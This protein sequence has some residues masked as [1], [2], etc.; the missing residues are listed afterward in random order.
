V[1]LCLKP[2]TRATCDI[3]YKTDKPVAKNA[4]K[5]KNKK[6]RGKQKQNRGQGGAAEPTKSMDLW[7]CMLY[8]LTE[9][10]VES[11]NL[12]SSLSNAGLFGDSLS[13]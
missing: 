7:T 3:R 5:P 12:I 13:G 4:I 10:F 9:N 1:K 8:C 6:N 11:F 2:G